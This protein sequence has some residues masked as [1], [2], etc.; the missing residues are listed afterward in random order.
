MALALACVVMTEPAG[1]N[2]NPAGTSQRESGLRRAITRNWTTRVQVSGWRFTF[3]RLE[4]ALVRRDTQMLHDPMRSTSRAMIVGVI[5]AVLVAAGAAVL[6]FLAPQARLNDADV[7]ADK[8]TGAL[9]VRINDVLHPVLNLASAQLITGSPKNP[10]FVRPGELATMPRGPL[11]GIPGAPDR[12]PNPPGVSESQW[13]VCDDTTPAGATSVTVLGTAPVLGDGIGPLPTGSA[14]LAGYGDQTFLVYDNKRTPIDLE[15]KAVTLAVGV[16]SSAP[17]VLPISRGL[18]DA[19]EET[20]ALVAPAIAAVGTPSPWPLDPSVVIGSVIKVRPVDGGADAFYVVL[21][22]GVQR[23]S[24]VTAAIIRN[25]DTR[26]SPPAVEVSPNAML[27]IPVSRALN[28]DFYPDTPVK[29]IDPVAQSV[30]CLAWTQTRDETK[31]RVVVLTGRSLPLPVDAKPVSVVTADPN[32][33]TANAVYIPP[34]SARLVQIA[35]GSATA[36]TGES[37]WYV[38]DTGVRYGL[39][40]NPADPRADPQSALGITV[41]PLP[42]PWSI[43]ALLPVGP[44]LSKQDALLAHDTLPADP[45]PAVVSPGSPGPAG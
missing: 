16:D 33:A 14:I 13:S 18:Y 34:G 15:D 5:L 11:V 30:T 35:G 8:D 39:V 32:K 28:V 4:H 17:P 38:A 37:V 10:T 26:N 31:P 24:A 6:S 45:N 12:T 2:A 41:A 20:P 1:R 7:V 9:Y 36:P 27:S 29:L 40:A 42:A 3:H 19:L 23:I 21:T 44:A 22:D 43:I 25:A